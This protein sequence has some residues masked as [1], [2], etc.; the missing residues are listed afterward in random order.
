MPGRACN[1]EKPA[2]VGPSIMGICGQR[3]SKIEQ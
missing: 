3:R 2:E 1:I